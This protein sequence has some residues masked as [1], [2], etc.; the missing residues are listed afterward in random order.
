MLGLIPKEEGLSDCSHTV[1]TKEVTIFLPKCI[2]LIYLKKQHIIS[3]FHKLLT[4]TNRCFP[5]HLLLNEAHR[6]YIFFYLHCFSLPLYPVRL[7]KEFITN[8]WVPGVRLLTVSLQPLRLLHTCSSSTFHRASKDEE[9]RDCAARGQFCAAEVHGERQPSSGHRL[10]EGQQAPGWRGQWSGRRGQEEEVDSDP[11]EPV[12]RTQR[13]VHLPGVQQSRGD[14]RHLQ[15]GSHPWVTR[16]MASNLQP[17]SMF[18]FNKLKPSMQEIN[19]E[20]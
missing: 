2:Y 13:E 10:A 11:E 4:C 12:A 7:L 3:V 5:P 8:L 15:G 18:C 14:Q 17:L 1:Q 16:T 6:V 20:Y 9:A 19:I